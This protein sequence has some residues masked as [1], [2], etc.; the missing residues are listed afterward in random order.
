MAWKI[1]LLAYDNKS[2]A[3]C[4]LELAAASWAARLLACVIS[5]WASLGLQI[6]ILSRR[7]QSQRPYAFQGWIV[8]D[9]QDKI[10][11]ELR[12]TRAYIKLLCIPEGEHGARMVSLGRIGSCE[13]RMFESSHANSV[14]V[15]LFWIELFD[16]DAQSAVDSCMCHSIAEAVTAF[17]GF[18]SR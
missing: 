2:H 1:K 8:Y 12:I 3:D 18:T 6:S 14:D 9:M 13:I 5:A 16:H 7:G 11:T 10:F 15:P 17:D 4:L